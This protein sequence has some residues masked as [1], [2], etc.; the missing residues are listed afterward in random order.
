MV[1]KNETYIRAV[2]KQLQNDS[3]T[4]IRYAAF[5]LNDGVSFV[6]IASIE[7]KDGENPVS[8]LSAFKEFLSEI[9][10]RCDE[11]PLL[12]EL[13]EVGCYRFLDR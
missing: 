1:T 12:N 8:K 11:S 4:G 10:E 2:F 7:T 6:H 9:E 5:K 13:D 3:P